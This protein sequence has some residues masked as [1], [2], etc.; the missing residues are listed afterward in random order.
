MNS[1]KMNIA[2]RLF[3]TVKPSIEPIKKVTFMKKRWGL[4]SCSIYP[5]EYITMRNPRKAAIA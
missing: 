2:M 4:S 5:R 1:Q 3:E